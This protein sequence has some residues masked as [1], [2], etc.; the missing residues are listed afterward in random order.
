M[1]STA[2]LGCAWGDEA[3]AKIVDVLSPDFDVIVRFQGGNN[4]GHTIQ[5]GDKT[6]VFHL[7]PSGILYP[8][9]TCCIASGVVIDPFQLIE[10]M[11][12]LKKSGISFQN[13]FFIDPRTSIVLPL[14]KELDSHSENSG[15]TVKIGTT[16]RGIGPCYADV[17][18]R[19]GIR[20]CD[21]Y[22]SDYLMQRLQNL[23]KFHKIDSGVPDKLIDDLRNAANYLYPFVKQIPY[24]L[25]SM[26]DKKIL[27]EGAQGALLDIFMGTYP[28]VT[29][30]HTITGSIAISC[31]FPVKKISNIIGIFK[32][33]YTRV[34][35]GPFPTELH[36]KI[37][38]KI[39]VRG[40]EYGST[41]GRPRRCGWFDAVA[42]KFTAMVNGIDIIALTL[43]DVFSSF[44]TLKICTGYNIDG[45]VSDVFPYSTNQLY[46]VTPVYQE[47]PG[48]NE[49]I[50]GIRSY[51]D[52]P[53]NARNYINFIEDYLK[54]PVKFISNG[55]KREQIIR[56]A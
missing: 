41:T 5:T 20:L 17:A 49:D 42:A 38:E 23:Y 48:W 43:L 21:L 3:K 35:E 14:H 18:T 40:N 33:Y 24:Y 22:E 9:K 7:V 27:F 19:I 25:N 30:S 37:G 11:E 53:V 1:N 16:R 56:K 51:K 29:S 32:S 8:G 2:V 47:L 10:E 54:K 46:R 39:R 45:K 13:R 28:F 50:S 44:K 34:G 31:G 12:N 36:D 15:D 52:L 26:K 4:A 55:P 6:Y